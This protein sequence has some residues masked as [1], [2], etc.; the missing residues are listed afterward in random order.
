MCLYIYWKKS[1]IIFF[2]TKR[3]ISIKL[4]TNHPTYAELLRELMFVQIKGQVLF[5]GEI[6][7]KIG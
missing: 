6:I 7:A 5:T 4:D 2:R 3:P 1:L